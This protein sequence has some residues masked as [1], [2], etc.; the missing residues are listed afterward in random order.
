[1]ETKV[2]MGVQMSLLSLLKCVCVSTYACTIIFE[3]NSG[4]PTGASHLN[5]TMVQGKE[6]G[7]VTPANVLRQWQPY[8]DTVC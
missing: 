4:M 1:M 3:E 6:S 7:V 5:L 2:S 8:K